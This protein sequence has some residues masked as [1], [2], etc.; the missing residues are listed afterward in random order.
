MPEDDSSRNV[1]NLIVEWRGGDQAA[2]ERLIPLVYQE[3]R[4]VASARLRGEH[5][6]H[7]L[8]TTALVNEAYVRLVGLERM[9]LENRTHFFAMAARLMREILVDHA[10]RK[11]AAKRGGG[12]T[13]LTLDNVAAGAENTVLDVLALDE[14]LTDLTSLDE[15][16]GRVVELRFFVGFSIAETS[17]ALGVS[18]ATVERDWTVAKAWLLQ[19][20]TAGAHDSG[21]NR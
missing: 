15:R 12:V 8:Q 13:L 4:R 18:S 17:D 16:L 1:T 5:A 14:A 20:L 6:N 10:R 21:R 19:R 11:H 2:L 3:L 7:T 9:T